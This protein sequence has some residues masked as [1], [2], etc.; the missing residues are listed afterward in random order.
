[1]VA[2]QSENGAPKIGLRASEPMTYQ[3]KSGE[4]RVNRDPCLSMQA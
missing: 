4:N 3:P 2:A 1:M